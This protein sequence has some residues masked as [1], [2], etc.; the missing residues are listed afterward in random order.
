[1]ADQEQYVGVS[2]PALPKGGGAIQSIGKGWGAVGAMGAASL[3]IPLPITAGRGYAPGMAISYHSAV[4]NGSVGWGWS[5]GVGAISRRAS[6]GVPLYTDDDV[7]LGPDGGVLLAE[8]N[9]QGAL[10]ETPVSQYNELALDQTY[11]VVRYFARDEG[12]FARI[13]HWRHASDSAGFWLIH[14]AD[15]DLAV[16]GR[17]PASRRCDPQDADR[18]AEW[19]LE[20]TVNPV[21]EHILYEYKAEDMAGLDAATTPGPGRDFSAQR[22]LW[23]VRYGNAK[24]HPHL[25]LW[26]PQQLPTLQWHFELILDY[27]ERTFAND[28]LPYDGDKSWEGRADF[29]SSFAY[30]F[31]LGDLR[32]VHYALMFHAFP[33]ELQGEKPTLVAALQ[34]NYSDLQQ[35]SKV[36]TS[37]ES[38]AWGERIQPALSRRPPVTFAYQDFDVAKGAFSEFDSMPGLDDDQPYQL[39]DL[40]GE[41]LAGV[42]YRSDKSWMY[43]EPLRDKE[44]SDPDAVKYGPW[45]LLPQSPVADSTTPV[46]QSLADL[47]GD[48]R[49]DWIVAQP[50]M[51]GFFT[52]KPDR[53]WSEFAP[54]SAFPPEF[55]HPQG[56]LADLVGDGLSDLA[57][58]GPR[59]VRLYA[60]RR[61]EGFASGSDIER[62][63]DDDSLPI[64]GDGASEL[65]AFADMF[66]S[67]QQHLVRIRHN[68]VRVWANLGR[69]R[70]GKGQL[71]ATLPFAYGEFDAARVRLADMDGSGAVDLVYLNSDGFQ[72][73]MSRSGSGLA[74]PVQQP[75]PDGVRYDRLCQ[76]RMA[77]LNGLGCSS[78]VLTVPHMKTRHWRFDYPAVKPYLLQGTE[79]GMGASGSVFYRSSAQEWLDE[80]AQLREAG[81]AAESGLPF[82]LHVVTRQTQLDEVTGN[83]FSQHFSFRQGYYDGHER[84]FRG[85]GLVIQ[86]D[87]EGPDESAQAEGFTAPVLTKTW[88]HSGR[89]PARAVDGFDQSDPQAVSLGDDLLTTYVDGDDQVIQAPTD[90]DLREKARVLAGTALRVEVFGLT[91]GT[92][93]EVPYSVQT[94]RYQVRQLAPVSEHQPYARQLPL[95]LESISYQYEGRADDPMCQRVIN[96]TWDEYGVLTH[97]AGVNYA[98][99]K[100]AG[101]PPPFEDE[102]Q[103]RWW[104]AAHDDAQQNVYLTEALAMP[105]HLDN[106]QAWRLGLPYLSRANA[107]VDERVNVS[108]GDIGHESFKDSSGWFAGLPRTLVSLSKQRYVNCGEGEASFQALPDAVELA[109]LDDHALTAYDRVMTPEEL[110]AKLIEVGYKRMDCFLPE[111]ATRT[112]WSVR[113]GF[114][115]YAGAEHFYRVDAFRPTASHGLSTVEY[116]DYSLLVKAVTA[117]DGCV[118]SATFSYHSL[119]PVKI[120]DPNRNSQ[121]A[122]YDGFG[123]PRLT[124]FYGTELGQEVGF[125]SL[126]DVVLEDQTPIDAIAHSSPI[127]FAT[128]HYYDAF[129]WLNDKQPVHSLSL[130]WD[131]YPDDPE[132]QLRMS[133]ASVDG[134][135]RTLQTRQLVEPG[136]AYQVVEGQLVVGEDGQLIEVE[137]DPRWRVSER[138]EYNN[139][140]LAVRVYRPYFANFEGYVDDASAREH[141]YHDQQFYDP[142]GRPTVTMTAKGWMRRVTYEGWYTISEDE[143]DTAEEVNAKRVEQGLPPLDDGSPRKKKNPFQR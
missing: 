7:L 143:N 10:V 50:G 103:Q 58:I 20:E 62:N 75:W 74:E 114:N 122:L 91:G 26:Q 44:A 66:G 72:V 85:F 45:E 117:P 142:L 82:A 88:Y 14:G 49:L 140:G 33:D 79:N 57:L 83:Q 92:P 89:Y 69:G 47:T 118:T 119:Q 60:S 104:Q 37:V 48:G 99:R 90:D 67:G 125:A 13:E 124:S 86:T 101:D 107:M 133:L 80:K 31:E 29:H 38:L 95:L 17:N 54:F 137:S 61:A 23:R 112:L 65:V 77:D 64:I 5:L 43:R 36:L 42:L 19:L 55:F 11:Q 24:A 28:T 87:S 76:V 84:E 27:G 53:N 3:E 134:F 121:E 6:K 18:V 93:H 15:G 135:G 39:V 94:S 41:G 30:G 35:G 9:S 2:A 113:R 139:K 141:W 73:F 25:Y 71:F 12:A 127:D 115:T 4:G 116:D 128:A 120:I 138:V 78:L 46:R 97:G 81:L 70:F 130:Q 126:A 111:D 129:S 123:V 63:A 102:H 136:K 98:R 32:F 1:M 105:I 22:Y 108:D 8:R 131:R 40:Y 109:E 110:T 34:L 106:A 68:E 16:Y 52:L 21:G 132:R 51:A 56:Q 59:S 96:L 100:V